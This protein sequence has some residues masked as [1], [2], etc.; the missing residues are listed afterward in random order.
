M[1]GTVRA[2]RIL[3]VSAAAV[4]QWTER[5]YLRAVMRLPGGGLKFEE[6]E[7]ERF[8]QELTSAATPKKAEQ[9]S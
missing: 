3:G 8:R 7:I 2:A 6:T 5:G 1:I 9:A 4:K